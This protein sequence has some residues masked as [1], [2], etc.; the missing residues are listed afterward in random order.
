M[1]I[2]VR[3]NL[4]AWETQIKV[5][6][7]EGD[8]APPYFFA[9][10]KVVGTFKD[11]LEALADAEIND[12][13]DRVHGWKVKRLSISLSEIDIVDSVILGAYLEAFPEIGF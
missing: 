2:S 12:S 4:S 5:H 6:K 8:S 10:K 7:L 11:C 1:A 9:D 13:I 3:K